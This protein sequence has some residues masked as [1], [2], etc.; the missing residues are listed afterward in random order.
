[1]PLGY[2][3]SDAVG[4]GSGLQSDA[5]AV[6]RLGQRAI[7]D[8]TVNATRPRTPARSPPERPTLVSK[9]TTIRARLV[10]DQVYIINPDGTETLAPKRID[11]AKVDATTEEDIARQIAEDD[12]EAR[13]DA[14]AY[15]RSIRTRT[16]LSQ[17]AFAERLR[18]SVETLRNWEQGKRHPQGPA[19]ALLRI[20]DRDPE[21]AMAALAR[22]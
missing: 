11:W 7:S 1:M 18:V 12:A 15:I 5:W 21:T 8:R 3:G 10:G 14:A 13:A 6:D 19:R 20:I 16:G 2:L 4:S 17:P 9:T 22:S